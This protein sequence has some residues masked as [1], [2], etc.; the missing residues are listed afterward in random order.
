MNKEQKE[1]TKRK[2]RKINS[3]NKLFLFYKIEMI[4]WIFLIILII[5]ILFVY[6]QNKSCNQ[7]PKQ[8]GLKANVFR[9][10]DK[11]NW[12]ILDILK[13]LLKKIDLLFNLI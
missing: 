3:K 2:A 11:P 10:A 6:F 8:N 12:Q 9:A 7:I 13:A 5:L 1:R 4:Q